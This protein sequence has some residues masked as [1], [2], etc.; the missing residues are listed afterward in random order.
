MSLQKAVLEYNKEEALKITRNILD[1]GCCV[2][3][4]YEEYLFNIIKGIGKE[5]EPDVYD[6]AKEHLATGIIRSIIEICYE[7]ILNENIEKNNSKVIVCSLE[8]ELHELPPRIISDYFTMS[9][10]NSYFL[11]VNIPCEYIVDAI[12]LLNVDYVAVSITNHLNLTKL[13]ELIKLIKI[14]TNA[15][16]IIGGLAITN[17]LEYS[18]NLNADFVIKDLSEIGDIYET[19]V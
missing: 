15:K 3:E 13:G 2:K 10:Y 6:I 1:N 8:N 19:S 5:I 4:F 18:N 16:I 17:N 11:G 14:S 12:N 9:G 7:Y